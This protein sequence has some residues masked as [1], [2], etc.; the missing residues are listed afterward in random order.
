MDRDEA[1]P[2]T[3][4]RHRAL[5]SRALAH[6]DTHLDAPLT[7]AGLAERAAMSPHHFHR[8]FAAWMGCSVGDYVTARRLRR[9]CA[10]LVSGDE[11]VLEVALAVGYESAQALA[12]AMRRELGATPTE[13]RRG[14]DRA[15]T[16]LIDPG[17]LPARPDP[18]RLVMIEPVR[19]AVLPDGVTALTA[20]ARGMVDRSLSRAARV[21]WAELY[22]AI[23]SAGLL[24]RAASWIA[25][26]PDDP[27][28]P[29]DPDCR[30]V[31]GVVFGLSLHD[32]RGTCERP[33]LPL[34]GTLAWE[35][36]APGTW[37]V[38]LHRGPYE[39][40]HE[41]W[42]AIYGDWAGSDAAVLRDAAPL[43]LML[44]DPATTAPEALLTEIWIPVEG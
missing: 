33:E 29:D 4:E 12:K 26:S 32:G 15:W 19:H 39:R 41:T 38:F 40:L 14:D 18:R 10:L 43:E 37:A 13:V 35:P 23:A 36:V 30:Y 8:V 16:R 20:T 42:R 21:A 5:I 17:P 28:G 2:T 25:L 31:A 11:P 22:P 6:V 34:A 7:A 3:G 24:P 27:K 9:A 44:N 1:P